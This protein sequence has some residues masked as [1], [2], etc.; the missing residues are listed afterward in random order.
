ML[1]KF[2]VFK[3]QQIYKA[4]SLVIIMKEELMEIGLDEHEA[5][6]YLFLLKNKNQT[7]NEISKEMKI[8]RS[9][10]YSILE[11]LIR[12]GLVSYVLINNVRNK[13]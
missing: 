7:A 10:V 2:V 8:N 3:K 4:F 5:E 11:R 13:C 12:K 1:Y 6:V 9:V